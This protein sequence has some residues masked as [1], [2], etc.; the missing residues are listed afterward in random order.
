MEGY[1][2]NIHEYLMLKH[3]ISENDIQIRRGQ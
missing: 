1:K 3:I 2:R